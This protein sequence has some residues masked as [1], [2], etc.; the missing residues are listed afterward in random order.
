MKTGNWTRG[1]VRYNDERG[2]EEVRG[3][4]GEE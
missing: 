1:E 2:G 3:V 4:G